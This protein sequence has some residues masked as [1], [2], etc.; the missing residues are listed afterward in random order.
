MMTTRVESAVHSNLRH[1]R[2]L[3]K[4]WRFR[5]L[6]FAAIIGPGIITENVNNDA[7]GIYTYSLA[8]A[9]YGYSLL[10]TLIPIAFAL[11]V[12][13]EISARMGA[14]TGK[15]LADLIREEFGFRTTFFIMLALTLTNL[16]NVMGEFAGVASSMELF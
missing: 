16:T 10:W 5:V 8:G 9:Q 12:V 14:A 3:L 6:M 4:R 11:I 15:G 13:Q 1:F 2:L 7:G